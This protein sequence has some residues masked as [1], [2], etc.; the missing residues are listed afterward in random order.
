MKH[1][2]MVCRQYRRSTTYLCSQKIAKLLTQVTH[3]HTASLVYK[4]IFT[5]FYSLQ[6]FNFEIN[7][8]SKWIKF[9]NNS[10]PP[11]GTFVF[12]HLKNLTPFLV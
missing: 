11:T 5:P 12:K 3:K 6:S 4:N 8:P 7:D 10:I 1:N 9:L 2:V